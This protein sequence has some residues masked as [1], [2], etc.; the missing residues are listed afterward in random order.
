MKVLVVG[1]GFSKERE[2]SLK[3]SRAVFEAL[4]STNYDVEYLDWDGEQDALLNYCRGIDVVFPVL[5]GIGGE[6]GQI[7]LL[8]EHSDIKYV[9]SSS[10]VSQICIDKQKTKQLLIKNNILVPNGLVMDYQDYIN[11]AF[12][13]RPHIVKPLFEGSSFDTFILNGDVSEEKLTNIKKAFSDNHQM[14]VEEFIKGDEITVPVL[15]GRHLPVIEIIPPEGQWFNYANKY[16]G[17]TIEACPPQNV[18]QQKQT[19]AILLA[20]KVHEIMGARHYSRVDMI[21]RGDQIF[22]LE[23]NTIPGMTSQSLFPKAALVAG[24]NMETLV[25]YLVD[26]ENKDREQ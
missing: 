8:L 11:S 15:E 9:G 13:E 6:D 17:S 26:L 10:Q 4:K 5:H 19:Q 18:S 12:S 16:N 3:S 1:G 20:E 7:Q 23:I 21:I 25:K 22:V 2:V 14:L 24:M